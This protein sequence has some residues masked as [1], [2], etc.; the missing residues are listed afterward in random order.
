MEIRKNV[1]F[2]SMQLSPW[3]AQSQSQSS[4]SRPSRTWRS[5]GPRG[6]PF[7]AA[8][9]WGWAAAVSISATQISDLWRRPEGGDPRGPAGW[10]KKWTACLEGRRSRGEEYLHRIAASGVSGVGRERDRRGSSDSET[11]RRVGLA[12]R[13]VNRNKGSTITSFITIILHDWDRLSLDPW[14][15]LHDDFHRRFGSVSSPRPFDRPDVSLTIVPRRPRKRY[16]YH[17]WS[18]L[19]AVV[20][21]Y[22][23]GVVCR[24]ATTGRRLWVRDWP[25]ATLE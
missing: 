23:C 18:D 21:M 7:R 8:G 11:G 20:F 12:G 3:L 24:G 2:S 4:R 10:P 9:S 19:Y 1:R 25:K 15:A 13:T 14:P 6:L 22:I 5:R 16:S 17:E